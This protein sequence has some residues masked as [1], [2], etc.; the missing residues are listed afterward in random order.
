MW[1]F[2][3]LMCVHT[4][5]CL[6]VWIHTHAIFHVFLLKLIILIMTFEL[7]HVISC[8][9]FCY[10]NKEAKETTSNRQN[11]RNVLLIMF[12]IWIS[13][14][15]SF[16]LCFADGTCLFLASSSWWSAAM[17]GSSVWPIREWVLNMCLLPD[18][19]AEREGAVSFLKADISESSE[20]TALWVLGGNKCSHWSTNVRQNP[21]KHYAPWNDAALII[22]SHF[23]D[24]SGYWR[25]ANI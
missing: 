20:R 4:S 18:N 19:L 13:V 21:P 2:V 22:K 17:P 25:F 14:I 15:S 11:N 12:L 24:R 9:N 16:C 23:K 6:D 10:W 5:A 7:F 1:P 3:L 8:Q